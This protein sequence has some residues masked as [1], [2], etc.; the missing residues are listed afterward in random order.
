MLGE[1]EVGGPHLDRGRVRGGTQDDRGC[2]GAHQPHHPALLPGDAA[3]VRVLQPLHHLPF[4]A[5][6]AAAGVWA[7]AALAR[8]QCGI[9]WLRNMN[10]DNLSH[11]RSALHQCTI[12][13]SLCKT[14]SGARE[15]PCARPQAFTRCIPARSTLRFV[16]NASDVL[17][18][19]CSVVLCVPGRWI[20]EVSRWQRGAA[21]G[22]ASAQRPVRRQ[23]RCH[24]PAGPSCG[25]PA[26]PARV[27]MRRSAGKITVV[28][29][30]IHDDPMRLQVHDQLCKKQSDWK[31]VTG[32]QAHTMCTV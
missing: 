8:K 23:L 15:M 27:H 18:C 11:A 13:C 5:S 20:T 22:P 26:P 6:H 1:T 7:V 14:A 25:T 16:Q 4:P 29:G 12:H 31:N 24:R 9:C 2:R 17:K 28:S 10:P 32:K 19:Q 3:A 30:E 21:M